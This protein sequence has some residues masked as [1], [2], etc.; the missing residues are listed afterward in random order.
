MPITE[1]DTPGSGFYP[2][3]S[4]VKIVLSLDSNLKMIRE[5]ECDEEEFIIF[6]NILNK[7]VD[8]NKNENKSDKIIKKFDEKTVATSGDDN[9]D[10]DD[11]DIFGD[12]GLS[13]DSFVLYT[14]CDSKSTLE[15]EPRR[16]IFDGFQESEVQDPD[17]F[18]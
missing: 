2:P 6:N 12:S 15:V 16:G 8:Q 4:S 3:V 11:D 1:F 5:G 7:R 18:M 17:S 9:D 13:K 14:I 10:N